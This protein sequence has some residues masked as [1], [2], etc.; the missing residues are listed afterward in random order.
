MEN[1][2][3]GEGWRVL[4]AGGVGGACACCSCCRSLPLAGRLLRAPALETREDGVEPQHLRAW[5]GGSRGAAEE[6]P[7]VE[8][9]VFERGLV[10]PVRGARL[11][12]L[13]P[14]DVL[15]FV[16][17]GDVGRDAF[18]AELV[19]GFCCRCWFCILARAA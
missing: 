10:L 5:T 18:A 8:P 2:A 19:V 4:A 16:L 13:L 15:V 1:F 9:P 6:E 12:G 14:L 11:M 17:L 3:F 7:S